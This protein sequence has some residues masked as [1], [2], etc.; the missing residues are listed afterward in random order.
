MKKLLGRLAQHL[1]NYCIEW[2][3]RPEKC[4]VRGSAKLSVQQ[5][6]VRINNIE[7][8]ATVIISAIFYVNI[9][10]TWILIVW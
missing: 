2:I 10:Y 7:S 5:R 3:K 1:I 9:N 6:K 8:I 4:I